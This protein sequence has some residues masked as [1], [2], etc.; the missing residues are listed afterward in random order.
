[1]NRK[2]IKNPNWLASQECDLNELEKNILCAFNIDVRR[3][4]VEPQDITI[5]FNM[6]KY[7]CKNGIFLK[8]IS[9]IKPDKEVG[10]NPCFGEYSLISSRE[11]QVSIRCEA[12]Q[13][14]FIVLDRKA[15]AE[16][17]ADMA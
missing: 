1:M 10:V 11:K 9:R 12:D 16:V 8:E 4:A 2:L 6:V 15:F 14:H 5:E 13:C 3:T 17:L 7:T